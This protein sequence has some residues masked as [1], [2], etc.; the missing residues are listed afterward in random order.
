MKHVFRIPDARRGAVSLV[1]VP[2]DENSSF[3]TGA[4]DAPPAIREA[5]HSPSSN[6]FSESGTDLGDTRHFVDA[7]D[8]RLA[9]GR[10]AFEQIT[11]GA[12]QLLDRGYKTLAL[13]GDHAITLALVRAVAARH[14]G[15]TVIQLDAHPDLYDELD[16]NRF[17]HACPFARIMEER[18]VDR[19]IQVGIRSATSHQREQARRWPVDMRL[20]MDADVMKPPSVNGPIYLTVD[21]DVLDPAFAPGVSHHEPGGLSTRQVIDLIHSLPGDVVGAD[22]V[23]YNPLRDLHQM[24]ATVAAKLVKEIAAVM[25]VDG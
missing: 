7:G 15:L 24:T 11:R 22:I 10:H 5:L 12:G 8:M 25:L 2:L 9:S 3:M 19:L 18:L 23:E 21:L 16:G 4:A 14:R 20:A 13:G 17:S 1:G 6:L